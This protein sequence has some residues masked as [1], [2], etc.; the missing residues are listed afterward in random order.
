MSAL[1]DT[2]YE[3]L[4]W[5]CTEGE[6]LIADS[7]SATTDVVPYRD[8]AIRGRF[9]IQTFTLTVTHDGNHD[10]VYVDSVRSESEGSATGEYAAWIDVSAV[11]AVH[12]EFVRWDV[13]GSGVQFLNDDKYANPTKVRLTEEDAT[14]IAVAAE[15]TYNLTVSSSDLTRGTT[16]PNG[17]IPVVHNE[18]TPVTA[19]PDGAAG[20]VFEQW[21]SGGIGTVEFEHGPAVANQD[22]R[23]TFGDAILTATFARATYEVTATAGSNGTVTGGPFEVVHDT[24]T[25][26]AEVVVSP[27]TGYDFAAWER[28]SGGTVQFDV[29]AE[30][31]TIRVTGGDTVIRARFA[32]QVYA[33]TLAGG[34]GTGSGTVALSSTSVAH[35]GSVTATVTPATGSYLEQWHQIGGDGTASFE[36]NPPGSDIW[37]ITV[38]DGDVSIQPEYSLLEY[39]V[40]EGSVSNGSVSGLPY[41]VTHGVSTTLADVVA[42]PSSGYE[43]S[44]W[45]RASGATIQFDTNR[46][47]NPIVTVT[48]GDVAIRPLFA[49]REYTLNLRARNTTGD[50]TD[51]TTYCTLSPGAQETVTHGQ[52]TQIGV[53]LTDFSAI[54]RGWGGTSDVSIESPGSQSTTATCTGDGT[55]TARVDYLGRPTQLSVSEYHGISFLDNAGPTQQRPY[56]LEESQFR[57]L[58]IETQEAWPGWWYGSAIVLET[59]PA[60]PGLGTVSYT[61]DKLMMMDAMGQLSGQYSFVVRAELADG[62][63]TVS[64]EVRRT[65]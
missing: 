49:L 54:F 50:G 58:M 53:S 20:Y 64:E 65:Y 57:V 43:F 41:T 26:L 44:Q 8:C 15:E 1:P 22:V 59:L 9:A 55:V 25:T 7:L 60:N 34:T 6:A 27:D 28:A 37:T 19:V 11:P 2:G 12:Y 33:I 24:P 17:T 63:F 62:S 29:N 52:P 40:T 23:V 10:A 51:M 3:F 13:E 61:S 35:G 31:P 47:A 38:T 39:V 5:E 32:R 4:D 56:A 14:I 18:W 36:E 16:T 46:A 30:Q 48:G 42:T 21:H 45:Q